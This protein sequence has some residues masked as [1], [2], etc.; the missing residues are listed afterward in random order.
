M[1]AG[2]VGQAGA[3]RAQDG[4]DVEAVVVVGRDYRVTTVGSATKTATAILQIPQPIQVVTRQLIEDQ[5]PLTISDALRNVSGFSALRNS[6]KVFRSLNI[7]GFQTL[8]LNVD[9]LRQTFGLN[10]Q[11]DAIA[12]IERI[13]VLKGPAGA[14]YGRGGLGATVNIVTKDPLPERRIAASI[15]TGTGGLIQPTLDVTGPLNAAGSVR[16]RLIGDYEKRDTATDFVNL[17]RWQIAGALAVDLGEHTTVSLKSD[18]REREGLRFVA[19][20][21]Y[22]TVTGLNDIRLPFDLFIG[23]PGVGEAENTGWTTTLKI[24]HSLTENWTFTAAARWMRNTLDL[25]F[26]NPTGLAADNRTLNRNY[27]RFREVES[28][29]AF[30][31]FV[32]GLSAVRSTETDFGFRSTEGFGLIAVT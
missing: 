30:D 20:P 29:A 26:V 25:P 3:A 21:A 12:S 10:D 1:A 23:E 13:E 11:P 28:E 7:R 18:Y 22:G 4:A 2:V 16:G 8:D 24:D 32:T 9:G 27:R 14:L 19:I 15:S 6:G 5:R 17:K 31:A